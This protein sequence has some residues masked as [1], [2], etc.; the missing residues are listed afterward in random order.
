[1][2]KKLR[3]KKKLLRRC[4]GVSRSMREFSSFES[5]EV[6]PLPGS[7]GLLLGVAEKQQNHV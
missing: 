6:I 5:I 1:M 2:S 3:Y 7:I 4:V